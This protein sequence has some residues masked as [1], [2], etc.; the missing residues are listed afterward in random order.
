MTRNKA[1]E[2]DREKIMESLVDHIN[3]S[4]L[5]IGSNIIFR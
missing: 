2:A 3:R 4:S 5:T 1:G